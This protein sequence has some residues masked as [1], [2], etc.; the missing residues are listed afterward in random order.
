[1]KAIVLALAFVVSIGTANAKEFVVSNRSVQVAQTDTSRLYRAEW[2]S[3]YVR[4]RDAELSH[5][6]TSSL[7]EPQA[8]PPV[9]AGDATA[10]QLSE[11]LKAK[12]RA[13]D[14]FARQEVQQQADDGS[15]LLRSRIRVRCSVKHVVAER[16]PSLNATPALLL[17][18]HAT[19]GEPNVIKSTV[20]VCTVK[21]IQVRSTASPDSGTREFT[22]TLPPL[23]ESTP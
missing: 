6:A 15:R 11:G 13:I 23:E 8:Q 1:L 17:S 20:E 12:V 4:S 19:S 18:Q 5:V 9:E 21:L 16:N 22:L 2:I 10:S 14:A 3:S 7:D